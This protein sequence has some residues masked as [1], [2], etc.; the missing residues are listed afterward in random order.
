MSSQRRKLA[1]EA[2]IADAF[3]EYMADQDVW[4]TDLR[5]GDAGLR[6]PDVVFNSPSGQCGLEVT[7]LLWSIQSWQN[8]DATIAGHPELSTDHVAYVKDR[9]DLVWRSTASRRW[10]PRDKAQ[11]EKRGLSLI[12]PEQP[13]DRL[14]QLGNE[15][16]TEKAT[17]T[18]CMPT[19]LVLDATT[20]A[21]VS[22][23]YGRP[24][25]DE[26]TVP[27]SSPFEAVYLALPAGGPTVAFLPL[28]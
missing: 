15:A 5:P 19:F 16:L 10:G 6:E 27:Q 8:L 24:I 9:G 26:L 12:Q 22:A 2:H 3:V 28:R 7:T 17:K 13:S 14:I 1:I 18:Y 25:V 23:K 21:I 4:L 20:N 11:R